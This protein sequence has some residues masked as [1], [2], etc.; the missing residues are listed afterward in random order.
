MVKVIN[1]HETGNKQ[2]LRFDSEDGGEVYLWNVSWPSPDYKALHPRRT[3]HCVTC[4]KLGISRKIRHSR[5]C[6]SHF[7]HLRI[8]RCILTLLLLTNFTLPINNF[9]AWGT[10]IWFHFQW[11]WLLK[12]DTSGYGLVCHGSDSRSLICSLVAWLVEAL[13]YKPEGSGFDSR[14]CHWIFKLT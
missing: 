11:V 14:W 12:V 6:Y 9:I 1:Q 2:S 13:C 3:R 8:I 10:Q 7:L 5:E 4:L